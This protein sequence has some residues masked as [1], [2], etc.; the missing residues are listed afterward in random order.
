MYSP[1]RRILSGFCITSRTVCGVYVVFNVYSLIGRRSI[2]CW[3]RLY[4]L[5]FIWSNIA[6]ID[7][8]LRCISPRL[9]GGMY[10]SCRDFHVNGALANLA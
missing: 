4:S 3:L 5:C 10:G 2:M 6:E 9:A 8:P 1:S 7:P